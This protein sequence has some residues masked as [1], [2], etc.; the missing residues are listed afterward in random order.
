M[1]CWIRQR[2]LGSRLVRYRLDEKRIIVRHYFRWRL[3]Q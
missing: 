2:G 1:F 3:R